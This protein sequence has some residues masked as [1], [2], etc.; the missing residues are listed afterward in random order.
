MS[1][2]KEVIKHIKFIMIMTHTEEA[3]NATHSQLVQQSR[4]HFDLHFLDR[5][6]ILQWESSY[7]GMQINM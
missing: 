7:L 1:R 4:P 6:A 3:A 2:G 5:K